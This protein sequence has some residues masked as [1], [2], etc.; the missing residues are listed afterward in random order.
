M[1]ETEV[2]IDNFKDI[3]NYSKK[4][5]IKRNGKELEL[6]FKLLKKGDIYN[7]TKER[8]AL[9]SKKGIV[10]KVKKDSKAESKED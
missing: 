8:Y 1:I 9:L 7:I 5:K 3:E 10:A 2:L 6:Q 4:T